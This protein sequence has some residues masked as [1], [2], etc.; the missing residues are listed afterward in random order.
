MLEM[1]WQLPHP[2]IKPQRVSEYSFPCVFT[3]SSV[4][5]LPFLL[6]LSTSLPSLCPSPLLLLF[7]LPYPWNKVLLCNPSWP[8]IHYPAELAEGW[9]ETAKGLLLPSKVCSNFPSWARSLL[10]L[11]RKEQTPQ[12]PVSLPFVPALFFWHICPQEHIVYL[13]FPSLSVLIHTQDQDLLEIRSSVLC[14]E[15]WWPWSM[16]STNICWINL[17][18]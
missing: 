3:I 6:S 14:P 15:Q 16:H 13:T 7:V 10:T 18:V 2:G 12:S 4:L 5:F 17:S 9:N 1:G 11:L 8:Y